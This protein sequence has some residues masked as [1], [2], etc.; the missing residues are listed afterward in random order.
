MQNLYMGQSERPSTPLGLCPARSGLTKGDRVAI[1][2][3]NCAEWFIRDHAIQLVGLISV[4]LYPIQTP[5]ALKYVLKHSDSKVIII[6]KLDGA[7]TMEAGIPEN[8][9]RIAMPHDME[10]RIDKSWDSLLNCTEPST[11]AL[12]IR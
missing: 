11:A 2:S 12:R 1:F 8:I 6:G 4:P 9:I 10:M 3:K 5:D 7:K